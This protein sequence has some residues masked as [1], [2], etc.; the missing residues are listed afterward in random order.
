[1]GGGD[2]HQQENESTTTTESLDE[3]AKQLYQDVR[4]V[5][6]EDCFQIFAENIT[7]LNKGMD[8]INPKIYIFFD[9]LD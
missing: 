3:K 1:M 4:E 5:L 6:S 8:S 2:S 7:S 9:I